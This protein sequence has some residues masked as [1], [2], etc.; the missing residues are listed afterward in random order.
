MAM[1]KIVLLTASLSREGGGV[2]EAVQSLA[3]ALHHTGTDVEVLTLRDAYHKKLRDDWPD[4]KVTTATLF[5]PKKYGF[6][7]D[8]LG[9]LFKT[10]ADI[11]HVHGLWMYQCL[12]CLIWSIFSRK[13]YFIT[14]HGMLDPWILHRSRLL[15][16]I[17]TRVYQR[18]FFARSAGVQALTIQERDEVHGYCPSAIVDVIPNAVDPWT[19]GAVAPAWW[20]P[21]FQGKTIF[22]FL[23]RIHVKKGWRELIAGWDIACESESPFSRD[24]LLVFCGWEDGQFGQLEQTIG[25]RKQFANVIFAGPAFG[26]EKHASF[27]AASVFCLPSF[28]EGLPLS[29]LEA[30]S[31]GV[32]SIMTKECNL[33]IGFDY[34][35]AVRVKPSAE[36]I[37]RGLQDFFEQPA[38]VRR[39]MKDSA[40]AIVKDHFSTASVFPKYIAFYARKKSV[41]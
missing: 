9:K 2:A 41:P 33:E 39:R 13:R 11:V 1:T 17:I 18:K 35:A 16:G 26:T 8:L 5:G 38:N 20:L 40:L 30:W 34:G 29:V 25:L 19:A 37:A 15:K 36:S 23:G 24:A 3:K 27:D 22:L 6:S 7:F 12:A 4:I 21:E 14:P 28:G 31:H 10:D 32:P